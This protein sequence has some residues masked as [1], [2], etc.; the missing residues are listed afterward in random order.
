MITPKKRISFLLLSS[1]LICGAT[2]SAQLN[3][4]DYRMHLF[5]DY[6]FQ[7]I[8][9]FIRLK[10]TAHEK[11]CDLTVKSEELQVT[12]TFL[13]N[14]SG[15]KAIR[16]TSM[17]GFRPVVDYYLNHESHTSNKMYNSTV[18]T[19]SRGEKTNLI[20]FQHF[21]IMLEQIK[22]E[23]LS[24]EY[25]HLLSGYLLSENRPE[26]GVIASCNIHY[27]VHTI[28]LTEKYVEIVPDR[29]YSTII[30]LPYRVWE[31]KT[32][33]RTKIRWEYLVDNE[34]QLPDDFFFMN[35]SNLLL[36]GKSAKLL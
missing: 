32:K 14:H 33:R 1:F 16:I 25:I 36:A 19:S 13:S 35:F 12:L 26:Q 11:C 9:N 18:L 30:S 7:I 17:K 6:D 31:K 8:E 27:T 21:Y 4:R 3:Q 22:R 28:D 5:N 23:L 29:S 24:T 20:S 15:W 10:S 2:V 34:H